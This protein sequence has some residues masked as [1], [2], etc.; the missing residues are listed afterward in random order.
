MKCPRR[1]TLEAVGQAHLGGGPV[2]Q[3]FH[4]LGQ[5]ALARSIDQPQTLLIIEGKHGEIDLLHDRPQEGR[6][7]QGAEALMFQRV[8]Q[9]IDF[10]QHLTERIT[11][12]GT[13]APEREVLLPQRGK[14]IGQGLERSNDALTRRE[15]ET[16]PRRQQEPG[17]RPLGEGSPFRVPGQDEGDDHGWQTRQPDEQHDVAIVGE[18]LLHA[19]FTIRASPAA[20][21]KRFG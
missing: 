5:Q 13:A 8:A 1:F 4:R 20:D 10:E 19:W 16:Q 12:P 17:E 15:R 6:G 9:G 3:T 11:L 7:F 21:K 14:K 2:E 18:A